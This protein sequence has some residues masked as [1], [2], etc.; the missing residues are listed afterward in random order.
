MMVRLKDVA[1]LAGYDI[2]TVSKVLQGGNIHVSDEAR[3]RIQKAAN[4][5][6][7]RPNLLA[8][9]LRTRRSGA[10]VLAFP[11]MDNP[12]YPALTEGAEIAANQLGIALFAYKF[13][14]SSGTQ[15][16]LNLVLQGRVDG[17]LMAD[18]LPDEDFLKIAKENKVPVVTLN[19]QSGESCTSVVLD[20]EAGF[21]V[22]A[23]YLRGLGHEK[24]VFVA[25]HPDSISSRVCR[26][27]FL[28]TCAATGAPV[29]ETH[30]L[31]SHFDGTDS[32]LVV[33][34]ILRMS[35]RPTAIATGSLITAMRLIQGLTQAGI[36]VPEEMSVI[37]YHDS[38]MAEWSEPQATTI[39]MP[40]HQQGVRGVEKLYT[41]ITGDAG[42]QQEI[43]STPIMVVERGSCSRA[44]N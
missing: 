10:L 43:I 2:S 27:A 13:P 34:E 41:L 17:V 44:R 23:S 36:K 29:P 11:R 42:E 40:S 3:E 38:P 6:G 8:R 19:R 35:P 37:G 9:G 22:Q 26:E 5:L 31:S 30:V 4:E 16:I 14:E 12:V 1:Y 7:Y 20:D 21:S 15:S 32:Q 24:I 25:V 33:G 28:E 18:D 39:R